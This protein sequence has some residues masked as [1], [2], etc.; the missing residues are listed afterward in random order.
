MPAYTFEISWNGSKKNT[1][2]H[3][4]SD[5]IAR[6]YGRI[7]ARN[8]KDSDQYPGAAS[9]IVKNSDGTSVGSIEF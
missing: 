1:W 8:F 3:L 6:D 9:L 5:D 7:L 4:P 2:A